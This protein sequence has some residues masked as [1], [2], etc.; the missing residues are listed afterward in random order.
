MAKFPVVRGPFLCIQRE[1]KQMNVRIGA[2]ES[3]SEI[4]DDQ[5]V[6]AVSGF[7]FR[8][9]HPFASVWGALDDTSAA[10]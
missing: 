8:A 6:I 10:T 5:C 4:S 3:V 7:S 1:G 9:D 2:I